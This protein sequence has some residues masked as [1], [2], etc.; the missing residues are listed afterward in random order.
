[1]TTQ[2]PP[3]IKIPQWTLGLLV[4]VIS[5]GGSALA[6]LTV[7]TAKVESVAQETAALAERV[8]RLTEADANRAREQAVLAERLESIQTLLVEV[9]SDVR[10]LARLAPR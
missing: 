7:T 3:S 9:R 10:Q 1:V 6:T 5:V 8:D 4:T 2:P